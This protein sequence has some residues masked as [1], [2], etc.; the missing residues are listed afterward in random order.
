MKRFWYIGFVS[1]IVGLIGV[2]L[3]FVKVPA[4]DVASYY[5][6]YEKIELETLEIETLELETLELETRLQSEDVLRQLYD[7]TGLTK[8]ALCDILSSDLSHEELI[9]TLEMYQS[10]YF[11]ET[12]R[13]VLAPLKAGDIFVF[14]A[15]KFGFYCHGHA[16]MVT[17]GETGETVEAKK[18]G[19]KSR[20]DSV[21]YWERQNRFVLLR[22]KE[23]IAEKY[24]QMGLDEGEMAVCYASQ[25]LVGTE[26][27]FF[28]QLSFLGG[29]WEK[30]SQCAYLVCDSYLSTLKVNLDGDAGALI[31]PLDVLSF[32]YLE[33][34]Q[35]YGMEEETLR[36]YRMQ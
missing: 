26:Y 13:A 32:P 20:I 9:A 24:R 10:S 7:Q 1:M 25:N 30:K 35:V 16:G 21:E 3:Y 28:P 17:D 12:K 34:V 11:G 5:P 14:D 27:S 23:E 33:V 36:R 2:L 29:R 22:L 19:Q 8:I 15:Q 6:D 31:T 18:F 4:V